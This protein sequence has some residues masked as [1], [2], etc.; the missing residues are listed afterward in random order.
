MPTD[1]IDL[2]TAA[3]ILGPEPVGIT[4]L[5]A[6]GRLTAHYVNG[7]PMLSR[8]EVIEHRLRGDGWVPAAEAW[9]RPA[10]DKH[11]ATE[12]VT[13]CFAVQT[14]YSPSSSRTTSGPSSRSHRRRP[15]RRQAFVMLSRSH[16]SSARTVRCTFSN[17][18]TYER[19][20]D[21]EMSNS[22]AS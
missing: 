4:G 1:L 13:G 22:A 6:A 10:D 15:P 3:Q 7:V 5:I 11:P 14:R 17:S 21:S 2:R 12:K 9:G 8:R 18:R 20:V 16:G 19:T